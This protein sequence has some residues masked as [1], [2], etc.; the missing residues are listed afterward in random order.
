MKFAFPLC[1]AI[2]LP[3]I[4]L[5]QITSISP[6][7][8]SPITDKRIIAEVI[9][10]DRHAQ[11]DVKYSQL[12]IRSVF[13][14]GEFRT[15]IDPKTMKVRHAHRDFELFP[16][17]HVLDLKR[18]HCRGEWYLEKSSHGEIIDAMERARRADIQRRK[19]GG[20]QCNW[21][22][23]R[24]LCY[25]NIKTAYDAV[26]FL[27]SFQLDDAETCEPYVAQ[28]DAEFRPSPRR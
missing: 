8:C 10:V 15:T 22:V 17:E 7:L 20:F 9:S 25:Q 28:F 23:E 3:Q 4:A 26:A 2:F 24:E 19:E 14:N 27:G 12:Q 11:G 18:T 5:A 13:R 21:P 16:G 1:L 6:P